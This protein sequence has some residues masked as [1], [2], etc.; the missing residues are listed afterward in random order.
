MNDSVTILTLEFTVECTDDDL[1][2]EFVT[3]AVGA[4]NRLKLRPR[5]ARVAVSESRDSIS[6]ATR[7]PDQTGGYTK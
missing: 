4:V 6:T 2:Q 3:R 5:F 7:E 1:A